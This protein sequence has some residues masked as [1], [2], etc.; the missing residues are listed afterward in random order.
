M[1]SFGFP[2]KNMKLFWTNGVFEMKIEHKPAASWVG[3][4]FVTSWGDNPQ[5][6]LKSTRS[7]GWR[8]LTAICCLTS[9]GK[10]ILNHT[11]HS[12]HFNEFL[13]LLY[14]LSCCE[15]F[16]W[17]M[18]VCPAVLAHF[19]VPSFTAETSEFTQGQAGTVKRAALFASRKCCLPE[20]HAGRTRT[21]TPTAS[22]PAVS[23]ILI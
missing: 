18:L 4:P 17:R 5:N 9:L 3:N 14:I 6:L 2:L 10:E 1:L 16:C 22:H 8:S 19:L 13:S 20:R 11:R 21:G 12:A 7:E 23:W 15:Q